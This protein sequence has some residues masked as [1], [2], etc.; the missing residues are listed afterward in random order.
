MATG[1]DLDT[2]RYANNART[3]FLNFALVNNG[4]YDYAADTRGFTEG[5]MFGVVKSD[6]S[7]KF[8]SF[9][10]PETANGQRYDTK[11]DQ[12]RA[13]NLELTLKPL[14][15]DTVVRFL[16][17]MNHGRMG[18][19]ADATARARLS[20]ATPDIRADAQAG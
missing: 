20:G 10:V 16:A 12:A 11:L 17:Y 3:Q 15:D 9:M 7:L 13:D 14:A 19:Y 18:R 8:G 2:N 5:V 6:W 1:D 4:A